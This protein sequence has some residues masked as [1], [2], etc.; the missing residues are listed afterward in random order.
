VACHEGESVA[1]DTSRKARI[2]EAVGEIIVILIISFIVG[3]VMWL[4][5]P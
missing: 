2:I 3:G 5:F 4:M 1:I